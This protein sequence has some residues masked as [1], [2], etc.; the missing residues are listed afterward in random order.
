MM[1]ADAIS[2]DGI[3]ASPSMDNASPSIP[4]NNSAQVENESDAVTSSQREQN[5]A[6]IQQAMLWCSWSIK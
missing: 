2:S 6:E 1:S 4:M 5:R 3:V